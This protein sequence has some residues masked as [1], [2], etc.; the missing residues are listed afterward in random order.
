MQIIFVKSALLMCLTGP[1]Q[2]RAMSL[3]ESADLNELI[4]SLGQQYASPSQLGFLYSRL[5]QLLRNSSPYHVKCF[6]ITS[7]FIKCIGNASTPYRSYA[8]SRNQS[9]FWTFSYNA[10]MSSSSF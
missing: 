9:V 10:Q 6:S 2:D 5:K 7:S 8:P 1:A 4:I 3:P